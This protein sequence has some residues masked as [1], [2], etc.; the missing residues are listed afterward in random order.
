MAVLTEHGLQIRQMAMFRKHMPHRI[1]GELTE[2]EY[3][4]ANGLFVGNDSKE[5][6]E[7]IGLLV[8]V[9]RNFQ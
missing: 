4:D 9:L 1:S 3:I 5:M 8:E 6:P 2:A 7:Q